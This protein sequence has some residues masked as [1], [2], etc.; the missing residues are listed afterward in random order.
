MNYD[1][2]ILAHA[3]WKQ[4]LQK[5][6]STREGVDAVAAGRDDQCSLGK[7]IHGEGRSLKGNQAYEDL[8]SKHAKFHSCIPPIL[9]QAKSSPEKALGMVNNF[10]GD[11]GKS[12]VEVVNAISNLRKLVE[13]R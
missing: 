5:A 6:I 2:M 3:S 13:K 9:V 4:K 7:W 10:G 8:K 12:T 1:E 11:F